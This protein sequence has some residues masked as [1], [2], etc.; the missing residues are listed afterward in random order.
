MRPSRSLAPIGTLPLTLT[1]CSAHLTINVLAHQLLLSHLLPVLEKTTQQHPE[2]D[3]RVVLEAS[4]LHRMT[5]G[6]PSESMGGDKFR[7]IDEFRKDVG[8]QS[9]YARC[10]CPSY[11]SSL[12]LTHFVCSRS[13]KLGQILLTK[14]RRHPLQAA[15]EPC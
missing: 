13:T 9:L 12:K 6:G 11:Q 7:T 3:V 4:E 8:V 15:Q 2:A 10:V 1:T 14:V 5:F